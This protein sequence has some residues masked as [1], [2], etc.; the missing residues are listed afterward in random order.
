MITDITEILNPNYSIIKLNR[1]NKKLEHLCYLVKSKTTIKN[2]KTLYASTLK[3]LTNPRYKY[4]FASNYK[5][6]LEHKFCK[7]NLD[8]IELESLKSQTPPSRKERILLR[9]KLNQKKQNLENK[10]KGE[11]QKVFNKNK[12][13]K[14]YTDFTGNTKPISNL[15]RE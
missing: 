9:K 8:F 4:I 10:F 3:I 1:S 7:I 5:N 6:Y 15:S 2:Y 12:V 11:I 14:I 13:S